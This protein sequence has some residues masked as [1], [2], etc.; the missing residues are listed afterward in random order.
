MADGTRTAG[1]VSV[2]PLWEYFVISAAF[3]GR[4]VADT[5][6]PLLIAVGVIR[7]GTAL[8]DFDADALVGKV[9]ER[10]NV[11]ALREGST[12]LQLQ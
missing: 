8:M 2:R 11:P 6:T 12:K 7:R 10:V 9:A 4:V 5:G 1:V 3:R